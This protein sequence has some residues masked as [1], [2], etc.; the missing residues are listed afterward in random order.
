MYRIDG[1]LFLGRDWPRDGR[2]GRRRLGRGRTRESASTISH[3]D[4]ANTIT[5]TT[6]SDHFSSSQNCL[7]LNSMAQTDISSMITMGT[8]V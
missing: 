5:E 6:A 3:S 8:I 4:I 2:P 1:R 7:R